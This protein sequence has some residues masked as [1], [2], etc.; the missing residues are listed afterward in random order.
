MNR[1]ERIKR[2]GRSM[3][4]EDHAK[5]QTSERSEQY[6]YNSLNRTDTINEIKAVRKAL[7]DPK[8]AKLVDDYESG[9]IRVWNN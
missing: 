4:L 6:V 1:E 5:G 7:R 8:I 2:K 3:Y 9:R